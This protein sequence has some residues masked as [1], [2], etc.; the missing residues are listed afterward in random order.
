MIKNNLLDFDQIHRILEIAVSV[1]RNNEENI[2]LKI[3]ELGTRV[4]RSGEEELARLEQRVEELEGEPLRG[5]Y[6]L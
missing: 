6:E 3:A 5:N 2:K 1:G 4:V